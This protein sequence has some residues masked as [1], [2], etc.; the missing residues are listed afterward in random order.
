M[1]V[2]LFIYLFSFNWTKIFIK[3]MILIP[4]VIRFFNVKIIV[5][6]FYV[7]L[8]NHRS[9]SHPCT[10]LFRQLVYLQFSFLH[11]QS[12]GKSHTTL[13]VRI[14]KDGGY[15]ISISNGFEHLR[16]P[17][18]SSYWYLTQKTFCL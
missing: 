6:L 13:K 9:L 1:E 5:K 14:G 2:T 4:L 8:S 15:S 18:N 16:C 11:C 12:N 3:E 7:L 10:F 17:I